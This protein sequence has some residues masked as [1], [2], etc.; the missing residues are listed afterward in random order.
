MLFD[1]RGAIM[2]VR[3]RIVRRV[4][5][6]LVL[7]G[8]TFHAW[9][10]TGP[11]GLP[12]MR[13]GD[14]AYAGAFRLPANSY[15]NSSLNYS[16]GPIEYNAADTTLFI[17]GHTYQ[18][19]IAEFTVPELVAGTVLSEL[20]MAGEP[21]QVF[22][23]VLD[24]T[25]GGNEQNLNRIGGMELV[26]GP[27]GRA[28]LVN[29]YEYY[30]APGDNTLTTL[31]VR[32]AGDIAGSGV[33]GFFAFAG[34]AGHT[35]G[36]LSPVPPEWR[37]LVGGTHITGH[38]SGIP[39]ISRCS[40]GPSA[41]AFDPTAFA[42]NV[43]LPTSI[44]TQ[45]LLDFS[46]AEPLHEDLSNGTGDNDLWTHLSQVTYGCIVPGT[47][48]YFTIG[49]SGGHASGV[50]YKCTRDDGHLC[51]GYCTPEA[52]DVYQ[53]YWLWDL[54]DMVAVKE[55]ELESHAVRPYE[56]G[57]F[58]TP[59]QDGGFRP[60]GGGTFDPAS[61]LLYLSV[62]GADREQGRYANPPVIVAYR[63]T[64]PGGG[65]RA[66]TPRGARPARSKAPRVSLVSGAR[67]AIVR[68][69]SGVSYPRVLT[70]AIHDP[71]GKRLL[72]RTLSITGSAPTVSLPLERVPA[73]AMILT[74]SGEGLWWSRILPGL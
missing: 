5:W 72:R 66:A 56:Y 38:S 9:C 49:N 22:S 45:R 33:E 62:R 46:L 2:N 34:G 31:V 60:I 53:Y 12:L 24:R 26:E 18:Q 58:D 42:A 55:D 32:D 51:G 71:A 68:I 36:W 54:A 6:L 25:P 20:H 30:D 37:E 21:V 59:F 14:L 4:L 17:V 70:I 50:C 69:T 15:G 1:E 28:L 48:T 7:A 35:A 8:G 10:Q 41:F 3:V 19:A 43:S 63:F 47:R 40:V 74:V 11:T 27:A 67:G 44:P 64:T 13:I 29:A 65:V 61:G 23:S 39:I 73:G 52:A 16:Q 57:R